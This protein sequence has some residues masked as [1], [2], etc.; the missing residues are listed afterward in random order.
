MYALRKHK[1]LYL[2]ITPGILYFILFHYVPMYGVVI[3]FQ[4]YNPFQKAG[5]IIFNPEWIGFENF[6]NFFSSYYFGR[7]MEN[8]LLISFYKL[9]F[10]FPAPIVL[11]LMLNEVYQVKLKKIIQ[12]IT[13]LPHFMSWVIISGL[14]IALLSVSSGPINQIIDSLGGQRINFLT[15]QSYFRSILVVSEI[16]QSVGWGSILY[17]AA[18]SAIDPGL[19]E[20]AKIDGASRL[21][22]MLHISLPGISHIVILL[23]VLSTGSLLNAGFEQILLLYSP[24][25]YDVADIIDTY[26]YREGLLGVRYSFAAAVGL[27]K[28]GLG[29]LLLLAVNYVV[30]RLGREGIW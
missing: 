6:R 15:D 8:T 26:V 16:W 5:N 25:V 7:L 3:A 23:F 18:L 21:Q 17:L 10:G 28:N 29:L 2:L 22:Q 12:T 14:L 9:L 27:F 24:G 11:A 1:F 13:Y 20:S 19:Y 30:R 4:D